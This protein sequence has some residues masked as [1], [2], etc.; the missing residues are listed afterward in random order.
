MIIKIFTDGSVSR[1]REGLSPGG[2]SFRF[3]TLDN[4]LHEKFG[5]NLKTTNNR[6]EL[7]AAIKALRY[8]NE[9]DYGK[10][11]CIVSDSQYVIH[12][13]SKYMDDWRRKGKLVN[14]R[15]PLKNKDLWQELDE[16]SRR[17]NTRW[18]WVRGHNGQPDNERCDRL[19]KLGSFRAQDIERALTLPVE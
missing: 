12:G 14:N 4:L 18:L 15:S 16:I 3:L 10:D 11:V 2:W 7:T 9:C 13:A 1:P 17:L 6:M 19:A 5:G 8:F